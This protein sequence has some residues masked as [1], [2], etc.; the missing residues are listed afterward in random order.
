MTAVLE[1]LPTPLHYSRAYWGD[2][3]ACLNKPSE[4]FYGSE[5]VPFTGRAATAAGR[6][7]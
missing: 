3:A 1:R 6:A 4:L 7:I 5:K 2:D